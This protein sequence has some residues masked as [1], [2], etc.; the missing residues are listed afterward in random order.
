MPSSSKRTGVSPRRRK[1]T[2]AGM[3]TVPSIILASQSPRRAQLLGMLGL[4]FDI[5]PADI[6][7]SYRK[8]ELPGPH[9]ERLSREKVE[10]VAQRHPESLVIASDTVVVAGG[11]V[12]GKP[13]N[14]DDAISMLMK[15]Q[16]RRHRVETGIA[17]RGPD[18]RIESAVESVVVTFRPF[19]E[20][21]ARAY[22]ATGEPHDKAG[23]YGIQGY[24]ATLVERIEGDFFA[25][26]GLPITRMLTLI[27][28][29]GWAYNFSGFE[30]L[31]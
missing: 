12:M 30:K 17:V 25:V 22:T 3:P 19:D 7:E 8:G 28:S 10:A 14:D 16:G 21:A 4:Q 24:G 9:A 2:V 31:A 27:R 6:D 5:I 18:G 15:L 29:L 20:K 11:E 1:K 23:A 26:M 13:K